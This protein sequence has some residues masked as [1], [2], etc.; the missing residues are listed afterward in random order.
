MTVT[1]T[2]T[3][4]A[5]RTLKSV[6]QTVLSREQAEGLGARVRR[7]IGTYEL[8]NL[9]PFLML[10]EFNVKE[11]AG[12][13]DHPHRGFETVTYMLSGVFQ[14]EDFAGHKGTIG[15]GDL[16]WM[17]AGRGI[18]HA[19]MPLSKDVCTGLQLWVNLPRNA[20]MIPPRYQELSATHV[21]LAVS[22][23]GKTSVKV[24]AGESYGVAAKV[25][26]YSPM[27]Y[28]DVSMAAGAVFEQAIPEGYTAFV[29]TLEGS[30]TFG[31]TSSSSSDV[32]P[33][34]VQ[35]PAQPHCT[36][37]LSKDGLLLR[38][39]TAPEA[40]SPASPASATSA[41]PTAP[42]TAARFVVIAGEPINEPIVQHGPFVMNSETEIRQAIMDYQLG[43]NGF[44]KAPE[45]E[46]DIGK[47]A[48]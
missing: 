3:A 20:K 46:S 45:W 23:D 37:V 9:D 48:R 5:A 35:Q 12:F 4:A 30:A 24:I 6:V 15:P 27:Y 8:R 22:P 16:Q 39:T 26:T 40:A 28:L 47:R 19:E 32:D 44:E 17:T 29:Y 18:V 43:R 13:P 14:H 34:D 2:A 42:K 41:T 1:T 31:D 25:H 38:A 7:S 21:P 11:P 33:A 36:L 10:D